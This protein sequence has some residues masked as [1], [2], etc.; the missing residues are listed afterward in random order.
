MRSLPTD[1]A[2]LVVAAALL[3]DVGHSPLSHTIEPN[4]KHWFGLDHHKVTE[5]VIRGE[6]PLGSHIARKL[7]DYGVDGDSLISLLSSQSNEFESIF[8][9]PINIDT[10]EGILRSWAYAG[11]AGPEPTPEMILDASIDREDKADEHLVDRFW[12]LKDRVYRYL[13]RSPDGVLFDQICQYALDLDRC[14]IRPSDFLTSEEQLLKRSPTLASAILYGELP[15]S[16]LE[17]IQSSIEYV[18]RRFLID[19][20]SAF[21]DRQDS[22]RYVQTKTRMTMKIPSLRVQLKRKDESR[23]L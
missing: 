17:R 5:S 8:S 13:I 2:N 21:L 23:F 9:G 22:A 19:R 18:E 7:R 16:V 1:K 15:G 10:I 11:Q 3:H 14:S 12:T 4:F 20:S 6:T